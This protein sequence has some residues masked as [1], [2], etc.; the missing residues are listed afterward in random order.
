MVAVADVK[1]AL[2]QS[3]QQQKLK[4]VELTYGYRLVCK[5]VEIER[6]ASFEVSIDVLG[7]DVIRDDVMAERLDAHIV[8]AGT[9]PIVVERRLLVGASLL[10]ED[11]GDDE[12]KVRVRVRTEAGD[13]AEGISEIV[14][15]RF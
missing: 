13:I 6:N 9:A 2:A 4:L 7:D 1:L 8:E 3:A 15:G 12:I 11:V 10:D 14:R 5:A